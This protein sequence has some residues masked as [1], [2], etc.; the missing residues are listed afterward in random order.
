MDPAGPARA[1][2]HGD[3]MPNPN[4]AQNRIPRGGDSFVYEDALEAILGNV[5]PVG[6]ETIGL[7]DSPGRVLA[8]DVV[9]GAD[10][11]ARETSAMDGYAVNSRDTAHTGSKAPLKL[12]VS[13]RV[14]AGEEPRAVL[15]KRSAVRIFTGAPLPEGADA[16][17]PQENAEPAGDFILIREKFVEKQ[18]VRPRGSDLKKGMKILSAG[19]VLR[20]A[21]AALIAGVG[22]TAVRVGRN[23]S[24]GIATIGNELAAPGTAL[25]AGMVYDVNRCLLATRC[26]EL[27]V[28]YSLREILK[29]D[30]GEL[31]A[32]LTEMSADC[33]IMV[34]SG[35]T[36]VGEMD[37][38]AS[39]IENEGELIFWNA[40]MKPGRPV[41]FGRYM[42]KPFFGL[43]GN[44]V[45][46]M[47]GFEMFVR[48]AINK[49]MGAAQAAP[50][51]VAARME[52]DYSEK[53]DRVRFT[54]GILSASRDGF[55]V[56]ALDPRETG[57]FASLT[58]TNCLIVMPSGVEAYTK[59]DAVDVIPLSCRST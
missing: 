58:Q 21:D 13:G 50:A 5:K 36:S 23:P 35:G 16:V 31:K 2:N 20:S 51:R 18:Y 24:V 25:G 4:G 9:A 38:T 37:F 53:S 14:E 47:I 44:P 52:H 8:E 40:K 49:M 29:D 19:H 54:R 7:F 43:P 48:P 17:V 3:L 45:S 34:T 55:T 42:G 27:R 56:R 22:G 12:R 39:L 32:A 1:A 33:D 26:E 15:E 41:V 28:T 30:Y 10:V 11:P 46:A 59:G 6:V 57:M